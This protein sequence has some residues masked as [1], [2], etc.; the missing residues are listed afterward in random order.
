MT[1]AP[2]HERVC[3][4]DVLAWEAAL[5]PAA[6]NGRALPADVVWTVSR[7]ALAAPVTAARCPHLRAA[8]PP[9]V[10]AAVLRAAGAVPVTP[11]AAPA[12]QEA[13]SGTGREWLTSREAARALGL[14]VHGARAAA[15][16]GRLTA[17][18]GPGGEWRIDPASVTE[19][20]GGAHDQTASP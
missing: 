5:G 14:T 12:S 9:G 15:R 6:G 17:A 4:L 3:H 10:L 20:R 13:R 8:L 19:Y 1:A 2:S 16:R 18:R 11:L 7:R